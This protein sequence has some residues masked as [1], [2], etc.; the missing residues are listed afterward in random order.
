MVLAEQVTAPVA[1]H[2]EGAVWSAGWGGLKWVDMLAGAVLSLDAATGAVSRLDVGSPVAAMVRPRTGGGIVVVT[3]REF[4]LWEHDVRV[5]TSGPVWP[6]TLRRFNEGGCDPTGAIICGSMSYARESGAGEVFR[7]CPDGTVERLL[8]GVTISNGL[9]FTA[10]GG[11]MYYV[12]SRTRRVDVFD[13]D[14]GRPTARRPFVSVPDGAGNPD[15]L[16]VD[17]HDGV[18]VAL[19]GGAAVHH[20]DAGGTLQ[21][22]VE[23]PVRQ[24]TSCTLGGDDLDTLFIT[25]SRENLPPGEQPRAGAVFAARVG[26]RGLP[27]L[28][29]AG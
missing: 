8:G 29:F 13:V 20:Y 10:D 27:V 11:R 14:G 15:G 6:D 23:V 5:R 24:V 17:E 4:T 7:M 12:D 1:Y 18:W 3:E 22:V 2:A 19:Y 16:W 21:D 9:G 28:P 25:T 26:V